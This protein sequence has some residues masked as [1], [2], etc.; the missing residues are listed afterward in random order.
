MSG[1][2]MRTTP[3]RLWSLR[4]RTSAA[5]GSRKC[6]ITSV[7]RTASKLSSAAVGV[8]DAGPHVEAPHLPT[9]ASRLGVD[10]DAGRAPAPPGSE[11][12]AGADVGADI[13]DTAPRGSQSVHEIEDL[14]EA[15]AVRGLYVEVVLD[16]R[17]LAAVVVPLD[18][19]RIETGIHVD[20]TAAH[21]ADDLHALPPR[22]GTA[23]R[24]PT[25]VAHDLL[26][27]DRGRQFH[28]RVS[29]A[30]HADGYAEVSSRAE[31]SAR[32]AMPGEQ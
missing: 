13:E 32:A 16:P 26:Q 20:E 18:A 24:L 17:R 15:A 6:S 7:N 30:D 22:E 23:I 21:A 4:T 9:V 2:V 14:A 12:Q 10:L 28:A 27:S 29:L 5:R 31:A 3:P 11:E 25:Q 1:V 8:Q 19:R